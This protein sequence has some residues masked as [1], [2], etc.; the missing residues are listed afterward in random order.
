[1]RRA[2]FEY[3]LPADRIAQWPAEPRDAARLM[4]VDRA[5][6]ERRADLTMRDLVDFVRPGDVWVVNDTRVRPAR[7]RCTKPS[8]GKVELLV[9]EVRGT[10]VRAMYGASKPVRPGQVLFAASGA[11]LTVTEAFG[12]GQVGVNLGAAPESWLEAHGEI[13]LPPYI[14]R[15]VEDADRQR[16]QTRFADRTGAVAAPTAGLHF[17][18]A[19][20]AE[21][22]TRGAHF[23]S[24]TLHVGP[25]TFRPIRVEDVREHTV[26][27]E[28]YD[29]PSETATAIASARRVVAVGTTVVR[30]LE[31]AA[32]GPHRV[33]PGA[34]VTTLYVQPGHAFQIVDALLTNLHLPGSSLLVLV[35]AFAGLERVQE[36][37]AQAVADGFRFYSYGDGMLIT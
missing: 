30:A 29:V 2:L 34:A 20:V 13:P 3:E 32:V 37:Y 33:R 26:D 7:I 25:G 12:A 16:Y 18:D 19:L 6:G 14:G 4:H 21:M 5:S 22:T 1:M 28:S 35:S 27:A 15:P 17:T 11:R 10:A 9:L 8:G 31:S 24:V 23:A 36:A